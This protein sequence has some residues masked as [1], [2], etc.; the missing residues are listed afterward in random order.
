MEAGTVVMND[1]EGVDAVGEHR[2][3]G[4]M[5]LHNLRE[6]CSHGEELGLMDVIERPAPLTTASQ[7]VTTSSTPLPVLTVSPYRR[8]HCPVRIAGVFSPSR[9]PMP[10]SIPATTVPIT[11]RSAH[12]P[13]SAKETEQSHSPNFN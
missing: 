13:L 9:P 12:R 2:F 4:E 1:G 7:P 3:H 8:L 5:E 6:I 10:P 11:A